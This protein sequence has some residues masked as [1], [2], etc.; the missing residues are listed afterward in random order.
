MGRQPRRRRRHGA[1]QRPERRLRGG[2]RLQG[3]RQG[4][5]S[6]WPSRRARVKRSYKGTDYR[7]DAKE[8]TATA[9]ID[10]RVV[11]ATEGGLKA[12]RRRQGQGPPRRGQRPDRGALQGG[13]GPHRPLLPRRPGP[14][15]HRRPAGEQ[16]PAG[17][18]AGAV[19]RRARRPRR[20]ARPCR[21]SPTPCASTRSASGRRSPRR[22]GGSGADILA[23]LPGDSWLGL[24]VANLG[25][26]LDRVV[27]TVAGGGGLTGVGVNALLGQFKKQTS[28][29]LRKDVLGWMGDAGVFVGGTTSA[30]LGGALVIKTTDPAK[31]KRTMTVLERF[32][33]TERRH[34]DHRAARQRASTTASRSTTR[35]GPPSRSPS[36]A[37][38]SWSRS[39]ARTSWPRRSHPASSSARRRPSPPRR[40]SS[41]TACG[42]R[43]TSTSP[44]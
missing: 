44:R 39:A 22:T 43:S 8:K 19:V 7:F 37:T 17:R 29:D 13:P 27:Q 34:E 6:C 42:P 18:R 31:T 9:L 12:D 24:G 1:A 33:R 41:A 15:P 38:A 10:H 20:S 30:D 36:P 32:A 14:R 11:V 40:A 3:R 35:P 28:L 2:H 21:P 25:Q 26:T 4:R 5:A 16:R 23:T